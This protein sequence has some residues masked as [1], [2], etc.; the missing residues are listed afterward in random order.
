LR[1]N[2]ANFR[3]QFNYFY[4]KEKQ[5]YPKAVDLVKQFNTSTEKQELE[6]QLKKVLNEINYGASLSGSIDDKIKQ[7][8][9]RIDEM[10]KD[11]NV[12][13]NLKPTVDKTLKLIQQNLEK[14]VETMKTQIQNLLK[15]GFGADT[16]KEPQNYQVLDS[17]ILTNKAEVDIL[18]KWISNKTIK[19][20]L[21]YRGSRDGFISSVF[22][23]KIENRKPTVTVIEATSGKVFGGYTDQEWTCG[24]AAVYKGSQNTFLFSI[25]DKEKYMIR[26]DKA[27]NAIYASP[28]ML[29][30]FGNG[31]DIALCENCA[32]STASY[33]SFGNA[34]DN[35]GKSRDSLAGTYY[36]TV[37][38]IEIFGVEFV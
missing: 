30:T 18:S 27:T 13:V 36:F 10:A 28:T 17:L 16:I 32:N 26:A 38:N 21:L 35:K 6:S 1:A 9:Q 12:Q 2:F 8:K 37:K 24:A 3:T 31:H 33:T 22:R 4:G 20:N 25:S 29:P 34:F 14:S 11:I 23:T 5:L 7:N 15:P 19:L